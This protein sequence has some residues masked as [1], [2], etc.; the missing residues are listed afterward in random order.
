MA[1]A[2]GRR[3]AWRVS[4]RTFPGLA[5]AVAYLHGEHARPQVRIASR[6]GW[7]LLHGRMGASGAHVHEPAPA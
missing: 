7:Q 6:A 3:F 2:C 1:E 5:R 4:A